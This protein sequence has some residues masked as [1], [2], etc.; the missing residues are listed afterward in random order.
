MGL[1]QYRGPVPVRE[2]RQKD[3]MTGQDPGAVALGHF[4]GRASGST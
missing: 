2:S 3:K 1:T 4:R